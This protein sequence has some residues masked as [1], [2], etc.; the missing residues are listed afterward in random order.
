MNE[1]QTSALAARDRAAVAAC[2]A[3]M[4]EAGALMRRLDPGA[5]HGYALAMRAARDATVAWR[6]A[7][8]VIRGDVHE[9]DAAPLARQAA[10]A[11]D[12]A[13]VEG[14]RGIPGALVERVSPNEWRATHLATERAGNP[15]NAASAAEEL[16]DAL[17]ATAG[18][19]EAARVI[20]DQERELAVL[21]ARVAALEGEGDASFDVA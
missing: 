8:D 1:R 17:A 19:D 7:R 9:A 18:D 10:D 2:P 20:R 3:I 13:R 12:A 4:N 11:L 16:G 21:R 6:L 14:S 15:L 5:R